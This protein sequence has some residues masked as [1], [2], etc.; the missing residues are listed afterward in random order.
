MNKTVNKFYCKKT[1]FRSHLI[2]DQRSD[3][4]GVNFGGAAPVDRLDK[5]IC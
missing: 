4:R 5:T 3:P 1:A 2:N